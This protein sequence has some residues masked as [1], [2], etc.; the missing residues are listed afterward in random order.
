MQG[1]IG[2]SAQTCR[3]TSVRRDFRFDKNDVHGS[4]FGVWELG[5]IVFLTTDNS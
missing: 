4:Q 5:V 2:G 1:R 3:R